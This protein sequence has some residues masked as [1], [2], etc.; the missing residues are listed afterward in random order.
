MGG[1]GREKKHHRQA[2]SEMLVAVTARLR[3][4]LDFVHGQSVQQSPAHSY[5]YL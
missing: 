5:L 4:H 3:L 2:V 1:I